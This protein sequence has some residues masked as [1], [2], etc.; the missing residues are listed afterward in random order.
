MFGDKI[1]LAREHQNEKEALSGEMKRAD[2]EYNDNPYA[3]GPPVE[4]ELRK[5]KTDS[6][7]LHKLGEEETNKLEL[8]E[9]NDAGNESPIVEDT[10]Q[11]K[12]TQDEELVLQDADEEDKKPNLE[13]N[14]Q[15]T[16]SEDDGDF[17]IGDGQAYVQEEENNSQESDQDVPAELEQPVEDNLGD[18]E[19]V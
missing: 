11:V 12:A 16:D 14:D 19:D 10:E 6:V 5:A 4:M 17:Q 13:N 7:V 15:D 3:K 2:T 9:G 18:V 8:V 1:D